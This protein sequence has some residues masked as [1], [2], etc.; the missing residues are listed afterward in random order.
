MY[1]RNGVLVYESAHKVVFTDFEYRFAVTVLK[2][3]EF[4]VGIKS[5]T[6]KENWA[7]H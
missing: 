2:Q 1:D 4:I 5:Q 6:L 7:I 3:G